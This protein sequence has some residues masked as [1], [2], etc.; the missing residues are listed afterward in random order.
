MVIP[1]L[2][3]DRGLLVE[4]QHVKMIPP[5]SIFELY[6]VYTWAPSPPS[7]ALHPSPTYPILLLSQER[8]E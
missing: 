2:R 7:Y 8:P 4:V 5:V 3:N 6:P 1:S